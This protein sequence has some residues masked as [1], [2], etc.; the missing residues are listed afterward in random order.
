MDIYRIQNEFNEARKYFSNIELYPT[1]DGKVYV[2]VA[3]QPTSQQFYIIT[4]NFPD[5]YPNAMPSIYIDK[6]AID[7]SSPHRYD[8]GS[9][10]YLHYTMWNPGVHNLSFVIQRAAKWLSKY[11]VWKRSRIWPGAEIKH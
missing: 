5:S 8:T 2:K 10:C 1:A 7:S 9:M 11:E 3:L 6:P 4:I